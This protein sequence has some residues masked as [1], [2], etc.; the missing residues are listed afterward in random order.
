MSQSSDHLG[1][2]TL[3]IPFNAASRLFPR[4][5]AVFAAELGVP[6]GLGRWRTT[7]ARSPRA[8][9]VNASGIGTVTFAAPWIPTIPGRNTHSDQLG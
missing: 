8:D 4:K 9:Q 3:W 2:Q 7:P 1:D 5:V 6:S